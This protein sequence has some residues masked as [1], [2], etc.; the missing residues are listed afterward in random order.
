M[1]N[2]YY[3]FITCISRYLSQT[4]YNKT[5]LA[6]KYTKRKLWCKNVARTEGRW[7]EMSNC[8]VFWRDA[9]IQVTDVTICLRIRMPA[10]SIDFRYVKQKSYK[11]M[12]VIIVLVLFSCSVHVVSLFN[13]INIMYMVKLDNTPHFFLEFNKIKFWIH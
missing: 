5:I 6:T 7:T 3:Q 11:L 4:Q 2:V 12:L 9:S 13:E 8:G 10:C 1:Y